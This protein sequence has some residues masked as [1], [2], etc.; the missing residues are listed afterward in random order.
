MIAT[1]HHLPCVHRY[2]L[3]V[4]SGG[5]LLGLGSPE[6]AHFRRDLRNPMCLF[7]S[8]S[9]IINSFLLL[10]ESYASQYQYLAQMDVLASIDNTV[11]S[12]IYTCLSFFLLLLSFRSDLQCISSIELVTYFSFRIYLRVS[13]FL[14]R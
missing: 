2:V 1:E 9:R 13:K 5:K 10:S 4:Y 14:Y 6:F 8:E 12:L 3:I 11:F 7:R